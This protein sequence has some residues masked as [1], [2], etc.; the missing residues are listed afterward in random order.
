MGI[1][2]VANY[3]GPDQA[4]LWSSPIRANTFCKLLKH[5]NPTLRSLYCKR[6]RTGPDCPLEAVQSGSLTLFTGMVI[7]ARRAKNCIKHAK[8]LETMFGTEY[9][10]DLSINGYNVRLYE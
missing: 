5:N 1:G 4:A 3:T 8:K 6:F 9:W 7:K 2:S 10:K